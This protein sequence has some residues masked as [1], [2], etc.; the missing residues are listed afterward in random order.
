MISLCCHLGV[1]KAA[2]SHHG[3]SITVAEALSGVDECTVWRYLVCRCGQLPN[4]R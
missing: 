1:A 2:L 4:R 3:S